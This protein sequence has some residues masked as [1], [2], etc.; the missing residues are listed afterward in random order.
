MEF[1]GGLAVLQ[2]V[3]SNNSR[4]AFHIPCITRIQDKSG[5]PS[6]IF[7]LKLEFWIVEYQVRHFVCKEYSY[8]SPDL[9]QSRP[10]DIN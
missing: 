4:S 3:F 1:N 5:H 8:S 7:S 9:R 2:S 10:P 6:G